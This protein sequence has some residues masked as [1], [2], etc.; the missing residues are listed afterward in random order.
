MNNFFLV[1]ALKF[2]LLRITETEYATLHFCSIFLSFKGCILIICS[3]ILTKCVIYLYMYVE[4]IL[5]RIMSIMC[6]RLDAI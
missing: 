2:E 4:P 1:F 5:A 3:I 6:F